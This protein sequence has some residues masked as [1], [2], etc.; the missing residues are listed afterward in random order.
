MEKEIQRFKEENGNANYS[1]KEIMQGL[2]TMV[3][4]GFKENKEDHKS[5]SKRLNSGDK[6]FSRLKV[7]NFVLRI[8]VGTLFAINGFMIRHLLNLK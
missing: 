7:W 8:A 2:H 5:M 1:P 6:E 4:D 3:Q